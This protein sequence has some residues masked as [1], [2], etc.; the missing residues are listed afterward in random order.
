MFSSSAPGASRAYFGVEIG[1]VQ[2]PSHVTLYPMKNH[3]R[4]LI[5]CRC[6]LDIRNRRKNDTSEIEVYKTSIIR[7]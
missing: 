7:L 2:R 1:E 3:R 5:D 6:L 4:N